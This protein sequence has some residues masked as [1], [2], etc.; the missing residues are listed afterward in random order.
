MAAGISDGV[1]Q[2]Y[3]LLTQPETYVKLTGG[4]GRPGQITNPLRVLERLDKELLDDW[5]EFLPELEMMTWNRRALGLGIFHFP[6]PRSWHFRSLH[7]CNL[8]LPKKAKL[9]PETWAWCAVKT[10]FQITDLLKRLTDR[11][12]SKSSG[13]KIENVEK[14]IEEFAE[15]G[16]RDWVT[17]A[18]ETPELFADTISDDLWFGHEN[19]TAIEGFIFYVKEWSGKVSEHLL[20]SKD[21]IGFLYSGIGRHERMADVLALYPLALGQGSMERV[22]GYGLQ[23]LPFHDLENQIMNHSVDVTMIASGLIFSGGGGDDY[24][25]LR[26]EVH[27]NGPLM[28]I[29]DGLQLSQQSFSNPTA[30]LVGLRREFERLGNFRNRSFG[31]AEYGQRTPEES[32]TGA[33]LRHQEAS[34][35]RTYEIARLYQQSGN[36]HRIRVNR[37]I[38]GGMMNGDPGSEEVAKFMTLAQA[39]GVVADDILGIRRITARTIFGDGDPNNQFLAL[40]DLKEKVP[41]LP[42]SGQDTF[43]RQAFLARLRDVDLVNQIFGSGDPEQ[44]RLLKF[45]SWHAQIENDVFEGS[46]TR[47]VQQDTDNPLIHSGEHTVYAEEVVARLDRREIDEVAALQRLMRAQAHTSG[48]LQRLLADPL[49]QPQAKDLTRRWANLQNRIRQLGQQ[50]EAKREKDKAAQLEEL[51]NPQPSVKDRETVMTEQVKRAAAI[52]KAKLEMQFAEDLHN[53]KKRMLL[54]G[55]LGAKQEEALAAIPVAG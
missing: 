23:M 43:W 21:G 39:D 7:P 40:M 33:R 35:S 42:L 51:R 13:W 10:E 17:S 24:K 45:Q 38:K 53:T 2:D 30:G 26:E 11:E 54:S 48:H 28:T 25:R 20:V 49:A 46:D 31:G 22:R 52:E 44:D 50:I 29:P 16:G 4:R 8:I 41:S 36:F 3:N 27:I 9:N 55:E 12:V 47:V 5:S 19:G 1:E 14:T 15:N 32:A 37:Y 34:S 18:R 6:H